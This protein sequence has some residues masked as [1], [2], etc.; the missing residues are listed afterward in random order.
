MSRNRVLLT[1]HQGM[2]TLAFADTDVDVVLIDYDVEGSSLF[3]STRDVG[4]RPALVSCLDEF[5]ATDAEEA[6]AKPHFTGK[7]H[8]ADASG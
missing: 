7:A 1:L 4:G 5:E 8:E 3:D 6:A 2:V